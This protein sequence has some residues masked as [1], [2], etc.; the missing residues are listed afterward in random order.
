MLDKV[1]YAGVYVLELYAEVNGDLYIDEVGMGG[2]SIIGAFGS[3]EC[4]FV[5]AVLALTIGPVYA[6]VVDANVGVAA[7][8]VGK[9]GLVVDKG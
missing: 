4:I 6:G 7:A 2:F 9:I 1:E 3:I 8:A 5:L